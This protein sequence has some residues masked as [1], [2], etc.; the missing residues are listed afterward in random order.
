MAKQDERA[1]F[2]AAYKAEARQG[3]WKYYDLM[4]KSRT[5]YDRFLLDESPGRRVLEYGCGVQS[6]ALR[7]AR[8]GAEVVGIDIAEYAIESSR[9]KAR[10][11]GLSNTSFHVMDAE[12]MAFPDDDFD[13]ICGTGILHHLNLEKALPELARVL[14]PAGQAVFLEPLGHNPAINAFRR[15]TPHLRTAD[16]HPLVRRDFELMKDHFD[17]IAVRYFTCLSLLAA[18]LV[19]TRI[20]PPLLRA[21]DRTDEIAFRVLPPLRYW[22]WYSA[23]SLSRPTVH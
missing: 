23:I 20:F 17:G 9:S 14:R 3:V 12:S 22:S 11:E 8:G 21:L 13:L 15:R 2:N 6:Y 18:P 7:M 4:A 16:E 1:F 19:R 5:Y 10:D